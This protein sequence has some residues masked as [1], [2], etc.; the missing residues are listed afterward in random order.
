MADFADSHVSLAGLGAVTGVAMSNTAS[1]RCY[2]N[3]GGVKVICFVA[4]SLTIGEGDTLLATRQG[5]AWWAI[6]RLFDAPTP[7]ELSPT[8]PAPAGAEDAGDP[9]PAPAPKPTTT[10]GSL[11]VPPTATRTYRGGSWRTD[12]D[13]LVQGDYGGFGL[14]TGCAFYGTK[15]RSLKGATVTSA[16]IRVRRT[17]GGFYAAQTATLRLVTQASKP[18]GAPTLTSSTTGPSL[19]VGATNDYFAIPT[20]WAQAMVNGTAGGLAIHI[21]SSTPYIRLAG[22]S[23]WSP[24]LTM[25]IK[26]KRVS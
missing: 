23:K 17:T 26:W 22:R 20:S 3:I 10:T 18:S 5:S 1:G 8:P 11:V 2:V 6:A 19:K 14:N 24:S 4:D 7:A 21:G 16:T 15:P 12:T 13:D 25:T 9:D